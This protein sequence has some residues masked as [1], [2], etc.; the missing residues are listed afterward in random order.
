MSDLVSPLTNIKT[1]MFSF[2][3]GLLFLLLYGWIASCD[4]C[5]L[6]LNLHLF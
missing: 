3:S 6:S 1:L 2:V 4:L 5:L